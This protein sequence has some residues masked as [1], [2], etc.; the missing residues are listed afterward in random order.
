MTEID[1]NRD[2]IEKHGIQHG[3]AF[4]N[5]NSRTK[6]SK[7]TNEDV[8]KSMNEIEMSEEK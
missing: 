4:T 3:A 5:L 1:Q 2:R 7:T 8:S 6:F